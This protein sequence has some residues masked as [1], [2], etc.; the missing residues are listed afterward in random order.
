M[1]KLDRKLKVLLID[2]LARFE[3]PTEIARSIKEEL[4]IELSP[5]QVEHYD[6]TKLAGEDLSEDLKTLF[7]ERRTRYLEQIGSIP[8]SNKAYR[9]QRLQK[10]V[11]DPRN[12]KN[13]V[14]VADILEQAAKEC[15]GHF[16][17]KR[18]EKSSEATMDQ[19]AIPAPLEAAVNKVYGAAEPEAGG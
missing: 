6:P 16:E 19:N 10:I 17:A 13:P 4:G 18:T 5:Q 8:I 9:L 12:A 1:S 7:E 3:T 11:D 2:R 14:L 15:G